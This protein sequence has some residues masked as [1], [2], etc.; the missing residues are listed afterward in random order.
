VRRK[1]RNPGEENQKGKRKRTRMIMK[2]RKTRRG[3][4]E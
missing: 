3:E 1:K 4:G 2:W